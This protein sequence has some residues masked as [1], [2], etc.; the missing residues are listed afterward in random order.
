MTWDRVAPYSGLTPW[1]EPARNWCS[2][3]GPNVPGKQVTYARTAWAA[4]VLHSSL[5]LRD[6]SGNGATPHEGGVTLLRSSGTEGNADG[7]I[8]PTVCHEASGVSLCGHL[9]HPTVRWRVDAASSAGAG[10]RRGWG[11]AP[12]SGVLGYSSRDPAPVPER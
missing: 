3:L 5:L 8:A 4:Q 6:L 7:V 2:C 10:P 1:S 11:A 12:R 9:P